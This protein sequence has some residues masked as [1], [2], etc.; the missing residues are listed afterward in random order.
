MSTS[1]GGYA[2]RRTA[3]ASC[4][5]PGKDLRVYFQD[6][7]GY[8]RQIEYKYAVGYLGGDKKSVIAE[9]DD[10]KYYGPLA[11]VASQ[12]PSEE[13]FTLP[14]LSNPSSKEETRY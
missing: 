13:V 8:I 4:F 3:I 1:R 6:F 9:A 14:S 12:N 7:D 11:V 5:V 10:V 2:L